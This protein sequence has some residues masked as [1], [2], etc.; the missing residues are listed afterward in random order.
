[1]ATCVTIHKMPSAKCNAYLKTQGNNPTRPAVNAQDINGTPIKL[2][3]TP[4]IGTSPKKWAVV[5]K[6]ATVQEKET[7]IAESNP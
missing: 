4:K 3:N 7:E 5:A 6:V 1:M 2:A